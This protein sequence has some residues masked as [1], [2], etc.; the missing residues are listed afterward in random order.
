MRR[1]GSVMVLGLYA[2][3]LLTAA[4]AQAQNAPQ[5]VTFSAWFWNDLDWRSYA[6]AALPGLFGGALRTG[7]VLVF[8]PG[9]DRV[10]I[11]G[12]ANA[13]TAL[14]SGT[15]AYMVLIQWQIYRG[16][17]D[18]NTT[19]FVCMAAGAARIPWLTWIDQ[20]A[21]SVLAAVS[22]GIVGWVQTKAASIAQQPPKDAP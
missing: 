19:F 18:H 17:V 21:K 15:V 5:V 11:E 3:L 20:T 8:T 1:T 9:I 6:T 12:I 22:D 4:I 7:Y 14:V 2:C 10:G 16:P 13:I